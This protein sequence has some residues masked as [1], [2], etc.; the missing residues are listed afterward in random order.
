MKRSNFHQACTGPLCAFVFSVL[1]AG[2]AD[3]A[4]GA[5]NEWA[6]AKDQKAYG[7]LVEHS[8]TFLRAQAA[9]R[10]RVLWY[11]EGTESGGKVPRIYVGHDM[12]THNS[13]FATLR[14]R[15]GKVERLD[16]R[17]DGSESWVADR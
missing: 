8:P 12:G 15:G 6:E 1:V 3:H 9:S 14:I 11:V 10:K 4:A 13:R 16:M 2:C 5:K 7:A 17:A